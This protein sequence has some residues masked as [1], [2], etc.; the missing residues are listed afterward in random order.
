MYEYVYIC[1]YGSSIGK[2]GMNSLLVDSGSP[3]L[4]LTTVVS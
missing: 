2:S 1:I 3:L 4:H